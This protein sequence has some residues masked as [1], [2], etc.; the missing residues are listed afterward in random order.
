MQKL[1][2]HVFEQYNLL[3]HPFYLAWNE[4][5]LTREQMAVYAGEYGSFIQ[6]ISEGWNTAGESEIAK[7]E[8][9]HFVLWK[10]FATSLQTKTMGATINQVGD[11]VA[12]SKK[13]FQSYA[14]ALGALYAFEAQQPGTASSKLQGLK[15]HYS[16][17]NADETYFNIHQ[18]DFEEPALLEQ[19]INS[20]SAEENFLAAEACK[21]TCQLLWNALSGIMEHTHVECLN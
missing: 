8:E 19:K 13:N 12:A 5:K 14:A 18:S 4:G 16:A 20:L 6:L 17:W 11:L 15:D 9:E 7:E 3:Q 1:F 21:E 2:S 10:D